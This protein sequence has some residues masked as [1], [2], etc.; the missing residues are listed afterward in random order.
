MIHTY[1]EMGKMEE[2]VGNFPS[3]Q[4]QGPPSRHIQVSSVSL[5]KFSEMTIM[6][7]ALGIEDV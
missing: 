4:V 2:L 3:P 7:D 6:C 5:L 1:I